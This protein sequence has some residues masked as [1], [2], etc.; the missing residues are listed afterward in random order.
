MSW[1]GWI[2]LGAIILISEI[3]VS[4]DFYLV[5][6]CRRPPSLWACWSFWG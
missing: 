2:A 5:F 1:W 3:I 4:T 6:F